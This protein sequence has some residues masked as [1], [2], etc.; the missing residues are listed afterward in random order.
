MDTTKVRGDKLVTYIDGY[1]E[2][3]RSYRVTLRNGREFLL[4]EGSSVMAVVGLDPVHSD[5]LSN[6]DADFC[7]SPST[8]AATL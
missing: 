1:D 6:V 3:S 5:R 4:I 8:R 2:T 7:L